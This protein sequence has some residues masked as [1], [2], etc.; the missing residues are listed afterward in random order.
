MTTWAEMLQNRPVLFDGA[1]GT[2]LME[3]GLPPGQPAEYDLLRRPESVYAVH[4]DYQT[5]GATVLTTCTFNANRLRLEQ[6]G[7]DLSARP[8]NIRAVQI[9]RDASQG[10]AW[11]AGCIGPTGAAGRL[12]PA[13][14]EADLRDAFREQAEALAESGVDLFLI[15]TMV[16]LR[17]ALLALAV[18]RR[19]ADIPVLVTLALSRGRHGFLTIAGDAAGD[20]LQELARE[21]ASAVGANCALDSATMVPLAGRMRQHIPGPILLQP[22]AGQ[23][24]LTMDGFRYPEN[25]A[26]Y[27]ENIRRMA[28]IGVD[29]LGGCCGTTPA[30]LAAARRAID[31]MRAKPTGEGSHPLRSE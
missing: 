26:T 13:G 2:Q 5:A 3:R 21:G 8:Y 12:G 10:R 20:A 27:A 15:E 4:C 16:D 14:A 23:P 1:M 28:E 31:T 29:L 6:A 22:C 24:Q 25:A 11:V 18:C 7:L 19:L 17:E 9:A 30:H